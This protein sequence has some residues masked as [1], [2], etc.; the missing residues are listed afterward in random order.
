M[1]ITSFS[2][3]NYTTQ[4]KIIVTSVTSAYI[5]H[6]NLILYVYTTHYNTKSSDRELVKLY[7]WST[8]HYSPM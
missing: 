2:A 6:N 8:S 1:W 7:I 3:L 5:F 4:L